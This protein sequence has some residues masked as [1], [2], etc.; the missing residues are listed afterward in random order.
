MTGW[1]RDP[2]RPDRGPV[3]ASV[4]LHLGVAGAAW[5]AHALTFSPPQYVAYE[6]NLVSVADPDLPEEVGLPDPDDLVVETPTPEPPAPEPEPT[7]PPPTPRPDPVP[8]PAPAERRRDPPPDPPRQ[9]PPPQPAPRPSDPPPEPTETRANVD[10]DVRMEG[11]QR[12]YPAYYAGIVA[13]MQACWRQPPGVE[14]ASAVLRFEIER[15]G[16]IRAR[17]IQPHRRSGN[18]VFDVRAVQAVECA[19]ENQRIPPLPDDIPG[20]RLP[21]Q[22]T[23]TTTGFRE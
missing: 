14:R 3:I 12:D 19:G 16:T 1:N 8:T 18:G 15:D 4:L 2:L 22:F 21:V 17:S 7:P 20:D 6:I 10:L 11:L 5:L 23:F 9:D 13:A